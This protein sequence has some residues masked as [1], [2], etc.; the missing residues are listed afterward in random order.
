VLVLRYWCDLDVRATAQALGISEGTVKS[1]SARGLA[2]VREALLPPEPQP[3]Q[4]GGE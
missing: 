3:H 1:A 2:T 4:I